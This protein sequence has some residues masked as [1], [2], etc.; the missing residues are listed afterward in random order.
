MK[1]FT[2]SGGRLFRI[3]MLFIIVSTVAIGI[4]TWFTYRAMTDM[5]E[6]ALTKVTEGERLPDVEGF[7]IRLIDNLKIGGVI[8]SLS[9]VLIALAARYGLRE[10]AKNIGEGMSVR[11]S[12]STQ[13]G[14]SKT[15]VSEEISSK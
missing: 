15:T 3:A 13:S 4:M 14:D 8:G 9:G 6:I 7:Y 11:S 1:A 10:T 2:K 12:V 5:K